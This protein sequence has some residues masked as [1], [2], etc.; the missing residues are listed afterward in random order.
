MKE[1]KL[2]NTKVAGAINN[3]QQKIVA[4]PRIAQFAMASVI[5]CPMMVGATSSTANVMSSALGVVFTIFQYVGIFLLVMSTVNLI[6][7]IRQEDGDR[8]QKAVVG[9][10]IAGVMIGLKL[11]ITPVIQSTGVQI[12][13]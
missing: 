12:T 8:Q 11:L 7:S 9:L 5:M 6:N 10:V 3:V 13:L 4:D 1:R 2:I